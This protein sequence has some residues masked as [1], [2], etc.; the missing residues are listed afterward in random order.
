MVEDTL[1][2]ILDVQRG[3]IT[4]HLIYKRLAERAK[5]V[6]REVLKRISEDELKH[7]EFWKSYTSRSVKP[8]M[9]KVFFY[10]LVAR[11]FG[12][13]FAVKLMERGEGRAEERYKEMMGRIVGVE[14]LVKEEGEHESALIRLIDEERLKYVSSMVL[15][16]NDALVELTGALAGF[17]F[18]LQDAHTVAMAGLITGIAAAL[19]MAASEYL[20]TKSE[21]GGRSPLKAASY[22][23]A[24]YIVTVFLLV[25]P[26]IV[27]TNVYLCLCVTIMNAVAAIFVFTFYI[28][29]A[30]DLPFKKRFLE[31]L[32]VGLG[33]AVLSF[34]LG[35][36]VRT[37][38]GVET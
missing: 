10:L 18:A 25:F 30:K 29:V 24:T 28:S 20:S 19:S 35:F 36:L 7:Y 31:M 21:G 37:L 17:T 13:T 11:L 14:G 5:G 6:N 12:L 32:L 4:E 23:G 8:D 33:V 16:L 22:T 9:L 15:G 26:F 2:K 27:I 34:A 3:E 1:G 38:F